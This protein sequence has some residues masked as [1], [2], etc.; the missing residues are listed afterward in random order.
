MKILGMV[1]RCQEAQRQAVVLVVEWGRGGGP[2]R[3]RSTL[4]SARARVRLL[5]GLVCSR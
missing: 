2:T 5:A 4:T 1:E 3:V